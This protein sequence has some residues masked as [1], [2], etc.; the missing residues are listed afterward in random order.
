MSGADSC[1]TV[2][3]CT[4][5]TARHDHLN[6][7]VIIQSRYVTETHNNQ[8]TASCCNTA[9]NVRVYHIT[10]QLVEWS[11]IICVALSSQTNFCWCGKIK[12]TSFRRTNNM[13]QTSWTSRFC[14]KSK[15]LYSLH[16]HEI[17]RSYVS[18]F[19]L[20][21]TRTASPLMGQ[22]TIFLPSI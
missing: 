17:K 2:T 5:G 6:N 9:V 7:W 19:T 8:T 18:S 10:E 16:N 21:L 12:H 20:I 13:F 4:D 14:P 1:C 11:T 15:D 22:C 3:P